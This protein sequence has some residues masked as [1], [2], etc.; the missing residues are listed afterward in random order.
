[1]LDL[2]DEGQHD[3]DVA[4][5]GGAQERTELLAEEVL[6]VE[7]HADRAP[8]EERVLLGRHLEEERELVAAEVEGPDVDGLMRE[9]LG[10][11]AVGAVLLLLLGLGAPADDEELGA[12]QADAL[13]AVR[14]RGRDLAGEVDVG[15]EQDGLAVRR[16]GLEVRE[17]DE[18]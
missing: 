1:L 2:V 9:A 12:E 14:A 16:D 13:G 7:A 6:E 15:A 5:R 18:L 3:A 10:D 17:E 4:V 11:L 8:A